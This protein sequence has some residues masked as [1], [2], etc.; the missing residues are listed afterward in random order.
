MYCVRAMG[1]S[2]TRVKSQSDSFAHVGCRESGFTW[3]KW[4]SR[5]RGGTL[6]RA[7][8]LIRAQIDSFAH[9]GIHVHT[10]G[11]IRAQWDSRARAEEVTRKHTC[12]FPW[13]FFLSKMTKTCHLLFSHFSTVDYFCS[14]RLQAAFGG[15]MS[16][17]HMKTS[18]VQFW[19]SIHVW[20][21]LK[22]ICTGIVKM[23]F[24]T[25]FLAVTKKTIFLH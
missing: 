17:I 5:V 24:S 14:K 20:R 18:L 2:C 11:L 4:D 9:V 16:S 1:L 22:V 12:S 10:L 19:E 13:F 8:R 25:L 6:V 21:H 7:E 23:G 15:N 3:A